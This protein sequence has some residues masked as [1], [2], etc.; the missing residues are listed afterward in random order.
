MTCANPG[1]EF[2]ESFGYSLLNLI[3]LGG[4]IEQHVPTPLDKLQKQI[5]SEQSSNQE[6]LNQFNLSSSI[7]LVNTEKVN[8]ELISATNEKLSAEMALHDEVL[9]EKITSNTIYIAVIFIILMIIYIYIII[10]M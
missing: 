6:L 5:Q 2:G 1:A 3:G 4:L 10:A 8:T 9:R 7:A